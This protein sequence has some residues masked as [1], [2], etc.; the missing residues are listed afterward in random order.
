LA[1]INFYASGGLTDSVKV[2]KGDFDGD[3]YDELLL[4]GPASGVPGNQVWAIS[5]GSTGT[6][7]TLFRTALPVASL[8][9]TGGDVDGDGFDELLVG[10]AYRTGPGRLR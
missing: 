9:A 3:G 5:Y 7:T 8:Q 4:T 1:K 6:A 10:S 2:E